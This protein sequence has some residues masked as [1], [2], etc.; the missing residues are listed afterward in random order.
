ML[1]VDLLQYVRPS[2]KYLQG[3][4]LHFSLADDL[5]LRLTYLTGIIITS[6]MPRT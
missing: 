3:Y 4:L 2:K 6:F 5:C 1:S